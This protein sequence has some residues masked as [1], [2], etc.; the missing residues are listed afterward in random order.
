MQQ[1]LSPI[2]YASTLTRCHKSRKVF[3]MDTQS[4]DF[5]YL[6]AEA[7]NLAKFAIKTAN[8]SVAVAVRQ[9]RKV[10]AAQS[11]PL[12]NRKVPARAE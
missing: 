7:R 2:F 11:T 9:R 12:P 4:E 3:A 1:T 8:R 6:C 5:Y 10:R